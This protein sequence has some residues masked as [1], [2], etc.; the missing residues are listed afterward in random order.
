MTGS[1]RGRCRFP[2]CTSPASSS[3]AETVPTSGR[4]AAWYSARLRFWFCS[5]R[6]MITSGAYCEKTNDRV[7]VAR[8]AEV[9]GRNRRRARRFLFSRAKQPGTTY[10]LTSR[11][12]CSATNEKLAE[13]RVPLATSNRYLGIFR[14]RGP[15]VSSSRTRLFVSPRLSRKFALCNTRDRKPD[16]EGPK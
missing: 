12:F 11:T 3:Y 5:E 9:K 2:C 7:R 14:R 10:D 13:C 16:R 4:R 15:V 8:L 6:R 1:C